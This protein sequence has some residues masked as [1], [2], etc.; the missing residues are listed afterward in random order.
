MNKIAKVKGATEEGLTLP[1]F[2]ELIMAQPPRDLAK[3]AIIGYGIEVRRFIDRLKQAV[4]SRR[5]RLETELAASAIVT[6]DAV[7]AEV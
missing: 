6:S 2:C 3:S 1:Q 5:N 4:E 7:L